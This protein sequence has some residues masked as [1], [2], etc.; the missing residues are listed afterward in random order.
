MQNKPEIQE[1]MQKILRRAGVWAVLI[2]L[3]AAMV[4]GANNRIEVTDY[5][6]ETSKAPFS[7]N[8]FQ[9]VQ[10]SDLH[11]Q[12]FDE[13]NAPLYEK[14]RALE[15]D[16]IVLTGDIIDGETHI[17]EDA[18]IAFLTEMP[19]IAPTFYVYGNHEHL[20]EKSQFESYQARVESTG[21]QLLCNETVQVQS[22]NGQTLSLIGMDDNSLQANILKTLVSEAP[23]DFKI[24]LAHEPQFFHDYYAETGVDLIFSGHVHGGQFRIPFTHIGLFAPDQGIFPKYSEGIH[25]EGDSTMVIS[26]GLG[27]SVFPFRL[28]N[29]PEIVRVTIQITE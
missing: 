3:F 20:L 21:V 29:H 28:F 17:N 24:M 16:L 23:D 11:N 5:V 26:R 27:N 8:G 22:H 7:F 19:Q 14:I 1:K 4:Y 25:Q 6:Y 13:N 15:P 9:I 18:A 10:I 12:V 2:L